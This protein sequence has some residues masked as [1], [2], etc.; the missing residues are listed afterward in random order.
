MPPFS[1][2]EAYP[3]FPADISVADLHHISLAKLRA[4]DEAESKTLFEACQGAGFFLLDLRQDAKGQEL[5]NDVDELLEVGERIFDLPL[6]EKMKSVMGGTRGIFGFKGVGL[7][8]VDTDGTPDRCEFYGVSKDDVMGIKPQ[9]VAPSVVDENRKLFKTFSEKGHAVCLLVLAHLNKH[10]RLPHG[11]L[12]SQHRLMCASG[13]QVRILKFDPQPRQDRRT[14]LVP[15]TDFGSVTVLFNILGGLQILPS[16]KE[17]VEAHWEYVKPER[18]HAII[19]IGD[20]ITKWTNGLL[21]SAMHRVTYAPGDQGDLTRWSLAYFSHAEDTSLMKRLEGSD[22]I[23]ALA[24]GTVEEDITVV[25]WTDA[26]GAK[27]KQESL[28]AAPQLGKKKAAVEV[29]S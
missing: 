29:G 17:N 27:Y 18:G 13:D 14:S 16:G 6:E 28:K 15:H 10:L 3:A 8:K 22:V 23:P 2:P 24:D 9:L 1:N 26:G 7:S 12:A 20:T 21:R 19:N 5:L 25:E 4:E 11:L